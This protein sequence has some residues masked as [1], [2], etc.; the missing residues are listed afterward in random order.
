MK[1]DPVLA[2]YETLPMDL[3]AVPGLDETCL[4]AEFL[5]TPGDSGESP[6]LKG[7]SAQYEALP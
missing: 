4:Q 3:T 5:L 7:I 6:M 1:L 2:L